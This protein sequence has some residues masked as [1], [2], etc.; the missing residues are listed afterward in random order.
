MEMVFP[1]MKIVMHVNDIS[2]H[3]N[4]DFAPKISWCDFFRPRHFHGK[5]LDRAWNF[6]P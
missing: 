6:H 1:C 3:E 2:I 4:E 5:V